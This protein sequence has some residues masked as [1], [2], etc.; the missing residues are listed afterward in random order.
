MNACFRTFL[1]FKTLEQ[2][3][4]KIGS[5]SYKQC[6][7]R[8]GVNKM[9]RYLEVVRAKK[10]TFKDRAVQF[11]STVLPAMIAIYLVL[12]IG[13]VDAM[14][15]ILAF[16]AA[17]GLFYLSYKMFFSFYLEWEYVFVEDE[18]SFSKIM[19]KS[20]RKDLFTLSLSK[21]KLFAKADDKD[22]VARLP[23][24]AKRYHFT[25]QTDEPIYVICAE[26][27]Q[28]QEVCIFWE[29]GEEMLSVLSHVI[30]RSVNRTI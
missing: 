25:S 8:K 19:N 28:G 24:D 27:K 14:F 21:T 13:S 26:T 23:Q 20:K 4:W 30:P 1:W 11:L 12:M 10:N 9:N 29:P 18:I 7:R 5:I 17:V 16:L 6:K 22:A 15:R 3:G 2:S